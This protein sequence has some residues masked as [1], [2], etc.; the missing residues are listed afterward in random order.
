MSAQ[1]TNQRG[2]RLLTDRPLRIEATHRHENT[3]YACTC[4]TCCA[5]VL[6]D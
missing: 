2:G 3:L 4:L 6:Y 5:A 1:I